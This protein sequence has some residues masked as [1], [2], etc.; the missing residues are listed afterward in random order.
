MTR[1]RFPFSTIAID[2]IALDPSGSSMQQPPTIFTG[3]Q[4]P[5]L[6]WAIGHEGTHMILG[7]KGANWMKRKNGEEAARLI[8]ANRGAEYDVE[9]ALCL[10]LQAQMS[11]AYGVT[12]KGFRSSDKLAPSPRRTLLVALENDWDTYTKSSDANAADFLIAETL[13][14]FQTRNGH[15]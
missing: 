7:P 5:S 15:E 4:V 12:P 14:T 6:A 13:R 1:L 9:E 3:L 8:K 11:I 10:L 2:L